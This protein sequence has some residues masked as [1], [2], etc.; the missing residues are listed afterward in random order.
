MTQPKDLVPETKLQGWLLEALDSI[1]KP[2]SAREVML[3]LMETSRISSRIGL[4]NRAY[5]MLR[6]MEDRGIVVSEGWRGANKAN[7]MW[8]RR[9]SRGSILDQLV[10]DV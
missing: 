9:F 7:Y 10:K 8:C 2:A 5:S 1:G 6:R 3:W 4:E